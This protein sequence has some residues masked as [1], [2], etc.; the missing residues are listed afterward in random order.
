L[1]RWRK[2]GKPAPVGLA[3]GR[4][5]RWAIGGK[6]VRS[7]GASGFAEVVM[8]EECSRLDDFEMATLAGFW[9]YWGTIKHSSRIWQNWTDRPKP[10]P[11]NWRPAQLSCFQ[12]RRWFTTLNATNAKTKEMYTKSWNN[13]IVIIVFTLFYIIYDRFEFIL[14]YELEL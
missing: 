4:E 6:L 10:N 5:A 11:A 9:T 14:K 1:E 13:K 12:K 8:K 7:I 3:I 2:K